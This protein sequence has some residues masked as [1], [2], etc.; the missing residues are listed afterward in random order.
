MSINKTYTKE[1]NENLNYTATWLPNVQLSLG[2]VGVL[3]KYAFSYRTN[4][5]KLGIP[6]QESQPGAAATFRH[7]S[8]DSVRSDLKISGAAPI[9]GSM[10]GDA[11]AG[12]TFSFGSKHAIVFL[13]TDCTIRKIVDQEPLKRA[14]LE[15][16]RAHV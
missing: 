12:I 7:V 9:A 3:D 5:K 10:L 14:I 2:D 13:A 1:L 6:Y 11:D 15:I 4:L 16:G 8:S